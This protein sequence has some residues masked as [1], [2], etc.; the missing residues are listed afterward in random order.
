MNENLETTALFPPK[1]LALSQVTKHLIGNHVTSDPVF[2]FFGR[3]VWYCISLCSFSLNHFKTAALGFPRI[4]HLSFELFFFMRFKSIQTIL[5][6]NILTLTASAP[7]YRGTQNCKTNDLVF[8]R[9]KR[10]LSRNVGSSC[11]FVSALS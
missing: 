5:L 4:S 9:V 2:S 10:Q 6:L 3:E 8:A 11:Y 7:L 1:S